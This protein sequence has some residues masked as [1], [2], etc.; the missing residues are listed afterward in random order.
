MNVVE[1]EE[2]VEIERTAM[3]FLA[4]REYSRMEL[5]RKLLARTY[6]SDLINTVLESLQHRGYLS[7]ERYADLLVRSRISTGFGPFKI[8]FELRDKGVAESII[9]DTLVSF[10]TDWVALAK[11]VIAKRYG[12]RPPLDHDD[13]A[14]QLRY[15]KNRG[16]YQQ[17][18]DAA[19]PP[20]SFV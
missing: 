20:I 12:G 11:K 10:D 18:L 4:R 1:S 6:S 17:H 8:K 19:L 5:T 3:R 15:L 16:F 7:D 9:D 14:R 13:L 2:S